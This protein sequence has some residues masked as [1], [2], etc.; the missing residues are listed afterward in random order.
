M[1]KPE[2]KYIVVSIRKS[3][4][5]MFIPDS[6]E[7]RNAIDSFVEAEELAKEKA[8]NNSED[9]WYVVFSC[10]PISAYERDTHPVK[11]TYFD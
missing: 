10:T 11:E 8:R 5:K 4:N 6:R 2:I 7:Q 1:N 9:Y 3:D